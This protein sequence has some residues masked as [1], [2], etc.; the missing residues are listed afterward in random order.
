ME[1][2]S[3]NNSWGIFSAVG[4][5]TPVKRIGINL[6][7]PGDRKDVSGHEWLG[8]PRPSSRNRLEFVFDLKPNLESGGGWYSRNPDSVTINGTGKPWIYASGARGL[9]SLAIP[10]L[11]KDDPKSKYTVKLHFANLDSQEP[12]AFDIQLQDEVVRESVVIAATNGKIT[13]PEVLQF[14]DVTVVD[15]LM[16]SLVPSDAKRLPTIAAIEVVKID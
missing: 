13:E 15:N 16:I 2:K 12:S 3:Q 14:D 4:P 6:G 11:G 5:T 1:P 7:A 10:L 8:Y 9:K